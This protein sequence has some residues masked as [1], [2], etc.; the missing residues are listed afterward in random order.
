[1]AKEKYVLKVIQALTKKADPKKFGEIIGAALPVKKGP[2]TVGDFVTRYTP[3]EYAKMRTFLNP[4]QDA[5][6]ALKNLGNGRNELVLV[7]STMPSGSNV[8]PRMAAESVLRGADTLDNYS[9]GNVLPNLYKKAGFQETAR[10]GFDPAMADPNIS[11]ALL[12]AEPSYVEMALNP[13][14]AFVRD[15]VRGVTPQQ[16]LDYV[17]S[18]DMSPAKLKSV[19]NL[20][21]LHA[22][23]GAGTAGYLANRGEK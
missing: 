15:S 23:A 2:F 19:Q 8:G 6:Y 3:E 1:M 18:G 14:H 11:P 13:S 20:L 12:A 21:A 22:L 4:T 16:W 10:Y 17:A 5:G 9:V 7:F